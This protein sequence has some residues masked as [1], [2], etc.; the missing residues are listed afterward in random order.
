MWLLE[1]LDTRQ[2][3]AI[4]SDTVQSL[5]GGVPPELAPD[6]ISYVADQNLV[7]GHCDVRAFVYAAGVREGYLGS[8]GDP[9]ATLS[10]GGVNVL[11]HTV[12]LG[13]STHTLT[14]PPSVDNATPGSEFNFAIGTRIGVFV[15]LF[16]R[17][18]RTIQVFTLPDNIG[19]PPVA[20]SPVVPSPAP[21][22]W[23]G[24]AWQ[25]SSFPAVGAASFVSTTQDPRIG[26]MIASQPPNQLVMPRVW[27]LDF[28]GGVYLVGQDLEFKLEFPERDFEILA[29]D[30]PGL[31]GLGSNTLRGVPTASGE[32]AFVA[33]AT[34]ASTRL[35]STATVDIEAVRLDWNP[36]TQELF[37]RVGDNISATITLTRSHPA[38]V[39]AHPESVELGPVW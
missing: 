19:D 1:A 27:P 21:Q 38:V 26:R 7:D 17:R 3:E 28:W 12:S 25:Q 11:T 4:I 6:A 20:G 2:A 16:D 24:A 13:S 31:S 15:A 29:L 5:I 30:I 23:N 39:E 22:Y 35:Y 10:L 18:S 14:F 8:G 32:F 33:R 36:P 34:E 37:A 9:S